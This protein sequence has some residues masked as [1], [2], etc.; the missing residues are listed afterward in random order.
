M[1]V[2]QEDFDGAGGSFGRRQIVFAEVLR[3]KIFVG[4]FIGV[5]VR[6]GATVKLEFGEIFQS[7]KKSRLVRD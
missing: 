2:A 3:G 1:N 6:E 4:I 5:D 7:L